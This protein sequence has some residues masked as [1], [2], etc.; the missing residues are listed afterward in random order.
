MTAPLD[1]ETVALLLTFE[2]CVPL[3]MSLREAL[4]KSFNAGRM[5][6]RIEGIEEAVCIIKEPIK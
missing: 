3:T 6:G 2:Q 1:A 5:R 4:Q